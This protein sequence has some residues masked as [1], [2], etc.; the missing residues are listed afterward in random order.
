M[1]NE[2][3]PL[4]ALVGPTAAGKTAVGMALAARLNGEI[5]SADAVAVFRGLDIGSAKPTRAEQAE[6]PF[7]LLDVARPDESFTLADYERLASAVIAGIRARGRT[8]IVVGG[9][10]LYVRAVTA[11][12]SIPHVEPQ[13]ALRARLWAEAGAQPPG[14]L[15]ARLA[16]LDPLSAAKIGPGDNKR[17]IRALE[18][19][20]VTG[21]PL[22]AFHTPSGVRGVPRPNTHVLG[23]RWDRAALYGRINARVDA[24]MAAGFLN[25]VRGLLARGYGPE[26]AMQSLGYRHLAAHLQSGVA[27]DETVAQLKQ[28]TRRFA[29]RQLSWFGNDANVRWVSVEE[30]G[31]DA[32]AERIVDGIKQQNREREDFR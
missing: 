32:V 8:P 9:T 31:P 26:K 11:I 14:F 18:V 1:S 21:Q 4:I 3:P 2:E 19:E 10:G 12:L 7:H 23:L 28:D 27:L 24:M 16:R 17:V 29:K 22:S 25:E 6:T 30:Q 15:H 13:H 5:V 20:A